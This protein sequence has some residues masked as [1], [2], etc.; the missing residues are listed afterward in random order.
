MHRVQD[1]IRASQFRDNI[2]VEYRPAASLR[3]LLNGLNDFRPQIVHFSGHGDKRGI[4]MDNAKVGKRADES[5]SFSLLAKAL[6]ATDSLPR[7]M[8]LNACD[9][10][11]ARKALLKLGLI[12]ISMKTSI[13]DGAAAMFAPRFYAAIAGGQ[14]IKSAFAQGKV[15]VE[16]TSISEA[17]TPQ[18]F[19]P[20]GIDPA[21]VILA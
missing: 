20:K 19:H 5:V 15:A 11:G 3:T 8:V 2:T 12:V 16:A 17:N 13:S 7:I 10:S 14:S 1:V 4:A 6:A 9:S 21:K 18:L